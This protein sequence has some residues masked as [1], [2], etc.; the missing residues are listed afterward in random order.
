MFKESRRG[1]VTETLIGQGTHVEGKLASDN[2][3]RIEG[4]FRGEIDCKGDVIVGEYGTARA[5]IAARDLTIAGKVYGD[6][7]VEGRLTIL[8]SGQLHGNVLAQ[9]ILVQDGGIFNGNCRMERHAEAKAPLQQDDDPAQQAP[10]QAP[11]QVP[12][13][14]QA[15]EVAVREKTRQAG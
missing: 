13:Q 6:V 1:D 3:I 14:V 12:Q 10:Q 2:G 5:A 8:A 4:E 15:R 11:Q 9:A 7:A